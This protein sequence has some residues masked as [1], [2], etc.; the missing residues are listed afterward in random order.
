MSQNENI[1]RWQDA[2]QDYNQLA[3]SYRGLDSDEYI[4]HQLRCLDALSQYEQILEKCDTYFQ[5]EKELD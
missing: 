2:L 4:V 3:D 1:Q 5:P